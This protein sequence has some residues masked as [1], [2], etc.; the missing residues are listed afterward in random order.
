MCSH[1]LDARCEGAREA[2]AAVA[3]QREE[4]DAP[5][6]I[7]VGELAE[8]QLHAPEGDLAVE[9]CR[10]SDLRRPYGRACN[11]L[12][13]PERLGGRGGEQRCDLGDTL[14]RLGAV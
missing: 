12:L 13:G 4:E 11:R 10:V 14:D 1:G 7:H 6:A 9:C 3:D 8:H 2:G 5:P